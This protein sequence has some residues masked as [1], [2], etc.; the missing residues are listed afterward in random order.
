MNTEVIVAIIIPAVALI[1]PIVV[2]ILDLLFNRDDERV[3]KIKTIQLE[4]IYAPLKRKIDACTDCKDTVIRE[5]ESKL[6]KYYLYFGESVYKD[7]KMLLDEKSN[8]KYYRKVCWKIDRYYYRL[9]RQLK[10]ENNSLK[11]YGPFSL[12]EYI[13]FALILAYI[14][15]AAGLIAGAVVLNIS[16]TSV[17]LYFVLEM[18][19]WAMVVFVGGALI[20]GIVFLCKRYGGFLRIELKKWTIKNKFNYQ[21]AIIPIRDSEMTRLKWNERKF[22]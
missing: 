18:S 17:W 13:K 14:S 6:E 19:L 1:V 10:Y 4:D 16:E 11:W 12:P 3:L 20:M 2:K 22:L 7:I 8:D 21:S 5:I 15:G 9:R